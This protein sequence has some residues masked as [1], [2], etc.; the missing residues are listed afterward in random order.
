MLLWIT[1]FFSAEFH[2]RLMMIS[3]CDL[4]FRRVVL[5][6]HL[7]IVFKFKSK[8]N[9]LDIGVLSCLKYRIVKHFSFYMNILLIGIVL[10]RDLG[11]IQ[12]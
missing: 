11:I 7:Y 2:H 3:T 12:I 8:Q 1:P 10:S 5:S 9:S 6:F 4:T